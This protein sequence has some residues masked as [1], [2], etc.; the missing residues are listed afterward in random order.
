VNSEFYLDIDREKIVRSGT[1]LNR[2]FSYLGEQ[3]YNSS[4]GRVYDGRGY[5]PVRVMSADRDYYDLWHIRNDMVLIDSVNTRLNDIG[6]IEKRRTGLTIQRKNQE[7]TISVGYE[8]IGSYDLQFRMA[9][10]QIKR[11]NETLPMGFRAG[12]GGGYGWWNEQKQRTAL[13]FVVVLVI[14]MICASMFESLRLPLV[15]VLLI[16]ISFIGL[17]IAYPIFGVSFGQGGF[18]AMIMLCG[19]TV[20]AGIY[21]TSEYR[22]IAGASG[23][24]G[25]KTYIKAYNRKIIPTMLTILSTV[26]GLIPFLFD[27]RQSQF[28]FSFA[29]GVMSG[30]MFS[31]IAIVMV[32]PVFFPMEERKRRKWKVVRRIGGLFKRRIVGVTD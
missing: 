14:F 2:Y 25:L 7:Y 27:G 9:Q 32:M 16:P 22:T 8:F 30:M 31:V 19:I 5:T 10:E 28:W 21:L 1:N 3:L 24:T 15:I 20:N 29:V 13:I 4:S 11:L 6:S 12:G 26:L 17:F 18:A 23:H